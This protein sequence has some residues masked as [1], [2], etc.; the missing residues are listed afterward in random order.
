LKCYGSGSGSGSTTLLLGLMSCLDQ[1][2]KLVLGSWTKTGWELDIVN[3]NGENVT[4][5]DKYV[6]SCINMREAFLTL[7]VFDQRWF[8]VWSRIF[9]QNW[10]FAYFLYL[11]LI[12]PVCNKIES[13][14][15][16]GRSAQ[17]PFF[18]KH[19]LL[20]TGNTENI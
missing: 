19:G 10:I 12:S 1:T 11:S 14:Y 13:E 6:T 7:S 17:R 5:V 20:L 15:G 2:C 3:I 8:I 4:A 16:R 18:V 9:S